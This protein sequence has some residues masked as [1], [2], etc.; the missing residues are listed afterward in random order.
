MRGAGHAGA[1][2]DRGRE[3][4]VDVEHLERGRGADDVDDGVEGADL[5]EMHLLGRAAVNPS[6]CDGECFEGGEGAAPDAVGQARLFDHGG[7]VAVGAD[8]RCFLRVHD[9]VG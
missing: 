2:G 9:D 3:H 5:V 1:V 6:F 4:L 8:D 7:D